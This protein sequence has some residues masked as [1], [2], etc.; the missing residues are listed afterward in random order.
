MAMTAT[1]NMG[2]AENAVVSLPF[3]SMH[4]QPLPHKANTNMQ[5]KL[6]RNFSQH[7]FGDCSRFFGKNVYEL[8]FA[9]IFCDFQFDI[10]VHVLEISNTLTCKL[11]NP[12]ETF[13]SPHQWPTFE[14][15]EDL[16]FVEATS[17]KSSEQNQFCSDFFLSF[18]KGIL[19]RINF[20]QNFF[21][22]FPKGNSKQNQFCAD[23][24]PFFSKRKF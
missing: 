9:H 3:N 14:L 15:L 23:F 18:P 13:S 21:L 24:F 19:N 10:L 8:N 22:S 11:T 17:P 6:S 12:R 7:I 4:H 2:A 16:Y 5:T 20:V 1:E